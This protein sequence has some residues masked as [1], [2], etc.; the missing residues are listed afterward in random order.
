MDA[1]SSAAGACM[2]NCLSSPE[3]DLMRLPDA[4]AALFLCSLCSCTAFLFLW[5]LAMFM[6]AS[7][8]YAEK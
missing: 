1:A 8:A 3:E 5:V 4:R 6:R 2:P 7:D